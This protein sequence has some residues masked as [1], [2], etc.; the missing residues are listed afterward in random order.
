MEHELRNALDRLLPRLD[1]ELAPLPDDLRRLFCERLERLFPEIVAP[2]WSIYGTHIDFFYHLEALLKTC[3]DYYT[4]RDAS[5]RALDSEREADPRWFQSESMVGGII[6]VDFFAENLAGV[7]AQ[8]PYFKELGLS[9]LHLMPVFARPEP[10]SDGGYAVSSYRDVH[11]PLGAIDDLHGL[12]SDLRA[13]GISLVL[14]FIFNHTSDE[15][16]WAKAALEGDPAYQDFY[17]LF[18]DRSLPD[19][20]ELMLREIFPEQA[21]GSFSYRA[22]MDRWVW[23]TFNTFQW[24]LNYRNPE[25]FDAML[26]EMLFLANLGVEV[27]R[28]DAVAFIWKEMGTTCENLPQAHQIIQAFN[29]LVRLAA[30][31]MVFKS[32]AIVHP[33]EVA[34]YIGEGECP[35]SYN[36]TLMALLWEAL[37]TREVHLLRH[38]M[39]KRFVH[40]ENC[41]WVNYIRLHDDIGWSFADEDAADLF[42]N[43]FDHRQFLNA[44]YTGTFDGSFAT[45]LLFNYN[46]LT[47]DGR[48]CG[49]FASLAGLES[50]LK[51][52]HEVHIEHAIRRMILLQAV[53]ISIGGIPLI[54]LGDELAALNDYSYQTNPGKSG[55][56]RWV[57]RQPITEAMRA[58]RHQPE[59]I[60]ARMFSSM[61]QM[62]QIRKENPVFGGGETHILDAHNP[63]VFAFVRWQDGHALL[64][65]FN[66]SEHEPIVDMGQFRVYGLPM[67]LGDLLTDETHHLYGNMSLSPYQFLWL[68]N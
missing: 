2:L 6:Y 37:A 13:E 18:P 40:P 45:G 22:E 17:Y 64:G 56:N 65:L 32:E 50:A 3:A 48:I 49:M 51:S 27:L 4:R 47:R 7:R 20:Y 60:A 5:L 35:I 34:K 68:M 10:Y 62:I 23:T 31:A 66:F 19:E 46:P 43:G 33:D 16:A 52:Q 15:H 67:K 12:A 38:S 36:P 61:Q 21:P 30:P 41:V 14:D 11:P 58:E 28:L 54:Y 57:H 53:N 9:Y 59:T 25:V 44:F 39:Q 63:H 55:D 8:I 26:G 29:A 42:I 24:D 1:N